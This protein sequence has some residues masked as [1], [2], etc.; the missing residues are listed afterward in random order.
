MAVR[1]LIS[2]EDVWK[3]Y[4]ERPLLAGVSLGVGAGERIAVVGRNGAGKSTLLHVLAGIEAPD[5]GRVTLGS[6]VRLGLVSQAEAIDPEQT[7]GGYV[8]PGRVAHEWAGDPRIREVLNGLLGGFDDALLDRRL[9]QMSGGERRRVQL[10]RALIADLDVLLLDEPTNHLD[11]DIV[12]WLAEH[13]AQRTRLAIVIVT[14]DRWFLDAL[15]DR[16]WEVVRGSVEEY[17]GGYSAYVLAKAERMRQAAATEARRQNLMR[18]ELAWL[19]RGPPA[20]TS[21]PKFRIDAA[22]EL[23]S[24]EP[25]PRD[26]V[27]LLGFAGARLGKTV[28]ELQDVTLQV[29]DRP[30]LDHCTW[31][32]GPGARIGIIGSN[33][34]GKTSLIRLLLGEIPPAQGSLVTG[35]T[36][37]PAYLSQHLEEL[38]PS[39]RVL[40]AV[41]QVA[42]RVD[43]GK[44]RE[45]SASQLCER[46]GFGTDGQWTP[47]GDL[48]G[49]ERRRLQLTRLL[50]SGP[51]VLILDEPTNDF[52]VETLTALEDLLDGFAGTLLVISHDRY[53]L[54]RVCDD[55]VALYGDGQLVDLPGGI[56]QYLDRMR[57]RR[58][59]GR[60]TAPAQASTPSASPGAAS[61]SAADRRQLDKEIAR[62][63]RSMARLDEQVASV[64][65]QMAQQA[66][67]HAQLADLNRELKQLME[68]KEELE[69]A[70]LEAA[71]RHA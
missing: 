53:F 8:V 58:A 13:L 21:K 9:G 67:D 12:A 6:D 55:V 32:I 7:V 52:D 37:K 29:G 62:I 17:D 19:R 57:A 11:V 31:N 42:G 33:G 48:S 46:L 71:E 54:E 20:R 36:V 43:L 30:L 49:G 18:K 35:V 68:A 69:L 3:A 44:G 14:H 60:S 16:T 5:A 25:P 27:Q 28:L 70:W 47:V 50:M 45:L 63:E 56:D 41:E 2:A 22:N 34:V 39:W 4:G 1:N 10:A 51:N 23:I 61:L 15:C 26:S 38:E 24:A 64:H 59:A 65:A 40:E 66:G